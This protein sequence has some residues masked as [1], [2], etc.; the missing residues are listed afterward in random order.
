MLL[1]GH[2][3]FVAQVL[4]LLR[5]FSDETFP[6]EPCEKLWL[7]SVQVMCKLA[8]L[9]HSSWLFPVTKRACEQWAFM[10]VT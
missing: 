7:L 1:I 5:L 4:I 3:L 9:D 10:L 2:F 8:N 6:L